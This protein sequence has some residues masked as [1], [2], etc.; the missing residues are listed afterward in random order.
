[1]YSHVT[2]DKIT[3]YR[4]ITS[5]TNKGLELDS[6]FVIVYKSAVNLIESMNKQIE[7]KLKN[8]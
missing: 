1:M 3:I 5:V 2:L 7:S 6:N 4:L 8:D